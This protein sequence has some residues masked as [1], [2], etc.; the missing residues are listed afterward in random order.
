MRNRS[1]SIQDF[2]YSLFPSSISYT[3]LHYAGISY[4]IHFITYLFNLGW[5]DS[6]NIGPEAVLVGDGSLIDP[7]VISD[8]VNIMVQSFLPYDLLID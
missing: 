7:V 8:A 6:R 1:F 5:N 2:S 3:H 4:K